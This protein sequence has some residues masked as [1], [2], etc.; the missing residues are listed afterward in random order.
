MLGE[1]IIEFPGARQQDARRRA[2][3]YRGF[4]KRWTGDPLVAPAVAPHAAYL[5]SPE[6]LKAVARAGRPARRALLIH[7]SETKT[8][9][10]T[11]RAQRHKTP[12]EVLDDLGFLRKGVRGRARRLGRTS[13]IARS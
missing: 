5:R 10:T 7:L 13:D 1:T 4:L 11:T 2:G 12:T 9:R 3:V 6:T 8:R